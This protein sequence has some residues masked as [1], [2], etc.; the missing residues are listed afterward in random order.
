MGTDS[1]P[2][3]GHQR[4]LNGNRSGPN[5]FYSIPSRK[6]SPKYFYS[7]P[8][9][10]PRRPRWPSEEQGAH[11]K[12][13][14]QRWD[15]EPDRMSLESMTQI[16][17]HPSMSGYPLHNSSYSRCDPPAIPPQYRRQPYATNIQPHH[18]RGH[19]SDNRAVGGRA[20]FPLPRFQAGNQMA[21]QRR[22]VSEDPQRGTP[23][24]TS[25]NNLVRRI[26]PKMSLHNQSGRGDLAPNAISCGKA[27]SE[28]IEIRSNI[29]ELREPSPYR[30]EVGDPQFWED[31]YAK[32]DETQ[33]PM[34]MPDGRTE[35][36]DGA[37][38]P[39]PNSKPSSPRT[40]SRAQTPAGS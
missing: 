37:S 39:S 10:H 38:A 14:R 1:I 29:E 6:R 2:D 9:S 8:D 15:R 11:R 3:Y 20:W 40:Q 4:P 31:D 18:A 32:A 5:T 13:E 34:N 12:L 21:G 35:N 28:D 26:P 19:H 25:R 16:Q 30:S 33:Q 22:C 36:I 23:S 7:G 27:S 17:R 24:S